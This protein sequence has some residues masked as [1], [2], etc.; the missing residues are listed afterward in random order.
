MLH[1]GNTQA[2]GKEKIVPFINLLLQKFRS[3]FYPYQ[4]LSL[5][6]MIIGFKGRW[7]FKRFNISKPKKYHIKIFGLCDSATGYVYN[8]LT[9]FGTNTSYNPD[10]D[11][12]SGDAVKIF[13]TLL[14]PCV[15][16]HTIYADRFYTTKELC[17]ISIGKTIL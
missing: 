8:I 11:T 5:D 9:Y 16:G 17:H 4:R 3:A 1:A 2:E 6:E 12:T 15:K 10:L 13:D 7:A 14:S